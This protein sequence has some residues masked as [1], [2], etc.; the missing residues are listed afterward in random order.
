[1]TKQRKDTKGRVLHKGE[2][3]KKDKKLYRYSYVDPMGIRRC[4]YSRN[5]TELRK[6][7]EQLRRDQMDGIG[8]YVWGKADLNFAFDRYLATKNDLRSTTKA[9]YEYT[10]NRYVRGG[11]GKRKLTEIKFSDVVLFYNALIDKGLS[12]N[13]V[14][15]VH[16]LLHP[17]FQ[18][19]VRDNVIRNN[20]SDRA[21]AEVR[22]RWDG[23]SGIRH[24]LSFEEEQAFLNSLEAPRNTRWKPLFT[25]MFGT[26]CRIG[27][28]IG[29]RWEDIDFD[30]GFITVEN[31]VTYYPKPD[32][33]F[34]CEY[35]LHSPKTEAGIR[36][37]P[38]LAKVR[39][40]LELE[41]Q[42]QEEFGYSC[43][44]EL[45]GKSGF[46]FCNRFGGL[47][48]PSTVNKTIKRIISDYNS[49]EVVKA[50]REKRKPVIIPHFSNHI[51]R[52]TFCT[53]LC[54]NETN[55]KVIQEVMGHHDIRT[56]MDIYAEVTKKKKK[57][58]FDQLNDQDV[59]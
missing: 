50:A 35:E 10:Y 7:E 14:D 55:A 38:M 47:L 12:A 6:K 31:N 48:K 46:V 42:N 43:K 39:E 25:V 52:H 4:V 37:I 20:P 13:T 19:A 58:I 28:I 59:I 51:T 18:L 53:R 49:E 24:A 2:D 5:L 44:A 11:F 54:E 33:D 8:I 56:T 3:Y 21:M 27:E 34:R 16:T 22:K 1:M 41:K 29:L 45:D 36:I 32:N 26:G 15:S 23:S 17:A 57:E 9:N 30:E 40:A